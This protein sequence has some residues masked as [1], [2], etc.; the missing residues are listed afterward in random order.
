[1]RCGS[2]QQAPKLESCHSRVQAVLQSV[3]LGWLVAGPGASSLNWRV[4]RSYLECPFGSPE[5]EFMHLYDLQSSWRLEGFLQGV[6][7]VSHNDETSVGFFDPGRC[8]MLARKIVRGLN[9]GWGYEES[10]RSCLLHDVVEEVMSHGVGL[11]SC[12]LEY[13]H[14]ALVAMMFDESS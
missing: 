6:M 11:A 8:S 2:L 1:M 9:C 12:R 4:P 5:R 13:E 14:T 3:A 7:L 10:F